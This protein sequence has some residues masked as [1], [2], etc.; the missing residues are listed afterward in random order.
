MYQ[1]LLNV[2]EL[3]ESL[4]VPVSWIYSRTRLKGPE[5]I[6]SLRIGKYHRFRLDDVLNWLEKQN[7]AER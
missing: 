1:N 7:E 2:R 6:P 4:N 3:A 5:A